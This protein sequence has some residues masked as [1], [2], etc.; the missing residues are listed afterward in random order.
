[1]IRNV[2]ELWRGISMVFK[3]LSGYEPSDVVMSPGKEGMTFPMPTSFGTSC[4]M[5]D[6]SFIRGV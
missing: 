2:R 5:V 4:W 1:M 3:F 6:V